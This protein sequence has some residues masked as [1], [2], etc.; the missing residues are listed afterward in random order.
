MDGFHS[1]LWGWTSTWR[2][3]HG[4]LLWTGG[5]EVFESLLF[6]ALC[7]KILGT[8][9]IGRVHEPNEWEVQDIDF[10]R[11]VYLD[12]IKWLEIGGFLQSLCQNFTRSRSQTGSGAANW[13]RLRKFNLFFLDKTKMSWCLQA[14]N[15]LW[16]R[17]EDNL[18]TKFQSQKT[19]Q[20]WAVRNRQKTV[21]HVTSVVGFWQRGVGFGPR[22]S[23]QNKIKSLFFR[24]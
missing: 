12:S 6:F 11:R 21:S 24:E 1:H 23:A 15:M 13:S 9:L 18:L 8:K 4:G 2:S 14:L 22:L 5:V 17:W 19:L 7:V 16:G 3:S 20:N 10:I